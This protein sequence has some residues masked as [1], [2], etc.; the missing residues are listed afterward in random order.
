M[1]IKVWWVSCACLFMNNGSKDGFCG[2]GLFQQKCGFG[3][4]CIGSTQFISPEPKKEGKDYIDE[5]NK[6]TA[7]Q[8]V[9][10][11][12]SCTRLLSTVEKVA[13]KLANK[14]NQAKGSWERNKIESGKACIIIRSGET[15]N[16]GAVEEQLHQAE[17]NSIIIMRNGL[18]KKRQ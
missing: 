5:L 18:W 4:A 9:V 11:D 2:C 13:G 12:K 1:L 7:G 14:F 15:V 16:A 3:S 6:C 8:G 10:L 17:V